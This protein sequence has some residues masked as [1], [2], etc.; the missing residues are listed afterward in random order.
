MDFTML[1]TKLFSFLSL[2]AGEKFSQRELA[3][4]LHVSPTAIANSVRK[5]RKQELIALEKVKTINF[6]SFNR[7]NKRAIE[8]KRVENLRQIYVSGLFDF[9][10]EK[11]AGATIVVFGSYIRG[12]DTST[13]DIDVAV[14]KRKDKLLLL[15]EFEK[16]LHRKINVNFYDSWKTIEYKLRNNILNGLILFGSVDL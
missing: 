5:L 16:N 11:L 6:I 1:E 10:E 9:L 8:L 4:N 14:I 3:K 12:E 7:S 2:C 15:E 13:S